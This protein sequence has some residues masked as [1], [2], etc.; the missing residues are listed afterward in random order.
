[1]IFQNDKK[2]VFSVLFLVLVDIF[3]QRIKFAYCNKSKLIENTILQ[4]D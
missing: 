4:C 1:M 2:T 3:D